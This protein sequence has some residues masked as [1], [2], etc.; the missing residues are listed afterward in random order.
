MV[1]T[2]DVA[3]C[4]YYGFG[5][6]GDELLLEAAV[7]LLVKNGTS[8]ERIAVFS[9]SPEETEKKLG[10]K[11]FN[12]W[13]LTTLFSV[14]RRSETLLL[15]GGGLFQDAS[16]IKSP[17]YYWSVVKIA[18]LCGASVWMTGQSVG[19]LSSRLSRLFAK[20]AYSS[21]AACSVRDTKSKELLASWRINAF[22]TPDLVFSFVPERTEKSNSRIM[23]F[24]LR[25]GYRAVADKT[26]EYAA[27]YAE[28][29]GL[30]IIAAGFA[31]EDIK[32]LEHYEA[33]GVIKLKDKVLVK[34]ADEFTAL[35]EN[36]SVSVGMR[37]HFIL[38]S[39][40]NSLPAVAG[41]YD[42]KVEAICAEF[43]IPGV[44]ASSP[45][46]AVASPESVSDKVQKSFS[47]IYKAVFRGI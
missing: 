42:P 46:A 36:A 23:L 25:P 39:W 6:L 8:K 17:V 29:H 4:G 7:N 45:S 19:P 5:N 22:L 35:A 14:L 43:G 2:F 11:A 33:C 26:A 38:L 21:C 18:R 1:R 16:S 34:S 12:R 20:S 27:A 3:L 28:E 47:A 40:L 44:E 9:A 32:E 15:G 31:E 41:K 13:S 10:I 37:Y 24:N 30:D